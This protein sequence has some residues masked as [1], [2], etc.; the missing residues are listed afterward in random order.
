MRLIHADCEWHPYVLNADVLIVSID[1]DDIRKFY[2]F[3]EFFQYCN[4]EPT[5]V[6]G[7]CFSAW[8]P[9]NA[10]RIGD[11]NRYIDV[12]GLTTI[13]YRVEYV[14]HQR[15]HIYDYV[16]N[17]PNVYLL[18]LAVILSK[19]YPMQSSVPRGLNFWCSF[20]GLPQKDNVALDE[21]RDYFTKSENREKVE[22][23]CI[24]DTQLV[25]DIF[26][27]LSSCL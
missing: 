9:I 14:N 24:K 16:P 11:M 18:D 22:L 5:M 26:D 6:I 13:R 15:W 3:P 19:R 21:I 25:K 2:T 17:Y 27:K 12:H 7:Y 8:R 10:I 4:T 1:G 20:L 23:Y